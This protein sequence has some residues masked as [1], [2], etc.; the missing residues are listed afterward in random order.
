MNK[1]LIIGIFIFIG[2]V[3]V[4]TS[5]T[6]PKMKELNIKSQI[7]KANYCE[8]NSDC[9]DAGGKCPFGCYVYVNKNEVDKIS[10]LIQSFNSKCVYGCIS[11]STVI[12]EDNV[13]KELFN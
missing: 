3:F 6:F 2:L 10:N 4:S 11:N 5:L 9:I 7:K 13:C 12:C 8:I 1:K